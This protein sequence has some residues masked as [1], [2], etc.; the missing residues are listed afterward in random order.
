MVSYFIF[1]NEKTR[2]IFLQQTFKEGLLAAAPVFT[3][4]LGYT[5]GGRNLCFGRKCMAG[6]QSGDPT[7]QAL[8]V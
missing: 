3:Y 4:R 8:R 1:F 5:A 6:Q 2:Y 7:P